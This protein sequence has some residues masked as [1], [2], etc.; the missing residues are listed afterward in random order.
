MVIGTFLSIAGVIVGLISLVAGYFYHVHS[1]KPRATEIASELRQSLKSG[2]KDSVVRTDVHIVNIVDIKVT[3]N[4]SWIEEIENP[5][6]NWGYILLKGLFA[7]SAEIVYYFE[8]PESPPDLEK[9]RDHP[10][11]GETITFKSSDSG[12]VGY[13]VD[14]SD[15][16]IVLN[17][18]FYADSVRKGA[19]AIIMTSI[20]LSEVIDDVLT[21][22]INR[23]EEIPS[24]SDYMDR[25]THRDS[26]EYPV[27]P[28]N[29]LHKTN[30]SGPEENS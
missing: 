29:K 9:I 17:V 26:L 14:I 24:F 2:N 28:L 7:G 25:E 4:S 16:T 21:G 13:T 5:N 11:Y 18:N 3:N 6:E 1:N 27:I 10:Y 23:M 19:A 8:Y 12:T 20:I 30:F 22:R 15:K